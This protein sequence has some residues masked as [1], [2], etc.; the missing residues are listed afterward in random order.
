MQ[1]LNTAAGTVPLVL[2]TFQSI[3]EIIAH[4]VSNHCDKW[5]MVAQSIGHGKKKYHSQYKNSATADVQQ[6]QG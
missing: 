2:V 3:K 5:L 1:A 4:I 6:A